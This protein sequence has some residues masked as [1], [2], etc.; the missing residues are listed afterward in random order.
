MGI[1]NA[2]SLMDSLVKGS[3]TGSQ[4]ETAL[5]TPAS[6]EFG[7]YQFILNRRFVKDILT[8][9]TA[10]AILIQSN[11][12][13]ELLFQ[14][15]YATEY[16]ADSDIATES[17]MASTNALSKF[18]DSQLAIAA[19]NKTTSRRN[20]I[21]SFVNRT[22][23]KLK[24]VIATSTGTFT[25]TGTPVK[26]ALLRI[27][28]GGNGSSVT[29]SAYNGYGGGGGQILN[30]ILTSGF[31]TSGA[32]ITIA[33]ATATSVTGA[34][35][36][37]SAVNANNTTTSP[38]AGTTSGDDITTYAQNV[39]N[40]SDLA[41]NFWSYGNY[42]LKGGNGGGSSG[43]PSVAHPL[44]GTLGTNKWGESP[45]AGVGISSGGKQGG[46]TTFAIKGG[47]ALPTSYGSGGG[48]ALANIGVGGAST[49]NG[50]TGFFGA[51]II[52]S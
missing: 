14:N 12:A 25:Y 52:I 44:L 13:L 19:Y 51:W 7:A 46:G 26:M 17:L 11:K 24:R 43:G 27:G 50:A 21:N 35:S 48:G 15:A 9:P 39:I 36:A 41:N 3:I 29:S 6:D 38:G 47:D 10:F 28:S 45:A 33:N 34:T 40:M 31:P 30:E 5:T 32:T 23:Y 49:G 20:R 4:L 16:L 22:G 18:V 8:S 2:I 42:S 1:L 37:A